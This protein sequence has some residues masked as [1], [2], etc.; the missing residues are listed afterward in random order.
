VLSNLLNNAAKF[1]EHGGEITIAAERDGNDAVVR[2]IDQGIGIPEHLLERIFDL[3][4]QVDT[5]LERSHSGLGV[6]LTI[7]KRLVEL[8]GGTIVARSAGPGRGSELVVRLALDPV[9]TLDGD[10]DRYLDGDVVPRRVLVVDDN[11][12][13]LKS[14]CLLLRSLGHEVRGANG[15]RAAVSLAAEFRPE[16]VLLDLAM[17]EC[18]G[19]ETA[20]LIREQPW[21]RNVLL[22]AL[23]GWGQEEYRQ[24]TKQAGFDRHFVKPIEGWQLQALLAKLGK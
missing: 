8:H 11:A 5:S 6:G 7:S 2:V 20:A 1:M 12:S 17:P 10:N 4:T 18:N 16:A 15:G 24:R 22:V 13:V 3:F 14:L 19:Y 9:Q 21:G 23:T